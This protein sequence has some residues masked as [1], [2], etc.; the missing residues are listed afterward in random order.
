VGQERAEL[1]IFS[2]FLLHILEGDKIIK[3]LFV[4]NK[5]TFGEYTLNRKLKI[6]HDVLPLKLKP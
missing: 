5:K 3:A 4:V 2:R 1:L 6:T